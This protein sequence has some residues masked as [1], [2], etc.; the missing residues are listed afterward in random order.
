VNISHETAKQT[1]RR[2]RRVLALASQDIDPET[3]W[4][5]ELTISEFPAKVRD[6]A[7][8]VVRDADVWSQLTPVRP[9]DDPAEPIRVW[10][11]HFPTGV[12]NSGFVGWLASHIKAATGSGVFVVCGQNSNAGGIYDHW[13]CPVAISERVLEAIGRLAGADTPQPNPTD[14]AP[15]DG[16]DLQVVSTDAIGDVGPGTRLLFEQDGRLASARYRGSASERDP[17]RS[18]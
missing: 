17:V 8:A 9:G 15:F 6:D 2:L 10:T 11:F 16:L 5:Q 3:R 14:A 1:D 7:I 4:F 13:G 12:D 18:R